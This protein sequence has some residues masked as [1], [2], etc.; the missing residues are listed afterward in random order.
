ME[1]LKLE[2]LQPKGAFFTL[3]ALPKKKIYIRPITAADEIWLTEKFGGRLQEIF[4]N[5][6]MKEMCQIVFHQLANQ[7]IFKKQNVTIY[8]EDTGE[9]L[10]KE[11]GGYRL[12][13][14]LISGPAEKE[15]M[16]LALLTTIGLSRPVVKKI[17]NAAVAE[18]KKKQK[19]IGPK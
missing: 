3:K 15:A 2:D 16:I 12:L 4:N 6:L 17:I 7:A 8:S 1:P 19:P 11:I 14:S 18:A 10:K 9:Q 13:L 5:S